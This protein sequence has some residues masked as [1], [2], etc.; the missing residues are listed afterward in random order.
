LLIWLGSGFFIVQEGHQAVVTTFGKYGHTKDA[1]FP[2]AL[3]VPDPGPRDRG[4]HAA[5]VGRRRPQ[6]VVQ[7]TGLKGLVDADPGREHRRHTLHGA[8]PARRRAQLPVREQ[9]ARRAV[10]MAAESAVREIV[11]RSRV[12]LVLY[13]QRDAIAADS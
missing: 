8:V 11:G 2:V 12:D 1:G 7:A 3:S 5:A 9:P 13:E 4:G 10:V 6:Y